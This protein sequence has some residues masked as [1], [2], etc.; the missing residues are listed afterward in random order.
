MNN[1]VAELRNLVCP[2]V[3]AEFGYVERLDDIWVPAEPLS[4]CRA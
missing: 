4:V 2:G 1:G 3:V